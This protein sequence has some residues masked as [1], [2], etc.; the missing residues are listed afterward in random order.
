MEES[1]LL[2]AQPA[3][4]QQPQPSAINVMCVDVR[5]LLLRA[6]ADTARASSMPA[7]LKTNVPTSSSARLPSV[8]QQGQMNSAC[9]ADTAAESAFWVP[10]SS[11]DGACCGPPP[12]SPADPTILRAILER[13]PPSATGA[14]GAGGEEAA[15]TQRGGWPV[16]L[17]PATKAA[18]SHAMRGQMLSSSSSYQRETP[19]RV[20][21]NAAHPRQ[22]CTSVSTFSTQSREK[23][24]AEPEEAYQTTS[25]V[26]PPSFVPRTTFMEESDRAELSPVAQQALSNVLRRLHTHAAQVLGGRQ[27]TDEVANNSRRE[28]TITTYSAPPPPPVVSPELKK[29]STTSSQKSGGLFPNSTLLRQ[30]NNEAHASGSAPPTMDD[31]YRRNPPPPRSAAQDTSI[32][33]G[34]IPVQQTLSTCNTGEKLPSALQQHIGAPAAIALY[35]AAKEESAPPR[36]TVPPA[37]RRQLQYSEAAPTT[38]RPKRK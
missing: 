31:S 9:S 12:L 34:E 10:G 23:A 21:R 6:A 37:F 5:E 11:A 3:A 7:Q 28:T 20:S 1:E 13:P 17:P 24:H 33:F 36:R 14:A 27:R 2:A 25:G 16:R 4:Q 26:T 19:Q 32:S 15:T 22:S 18:R 30:Q 8:K 29:W 35:G 38:R